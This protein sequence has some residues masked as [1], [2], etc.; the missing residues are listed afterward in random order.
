MYVEAQRAKTQEFRD[1]VNKA[2]DLPR[3]YTEPYTKPDFSLVGHS[4]IFTWGFGRDLLRQ[5]DPIGDA[6][7]LWRGIDSFWDG[8]ANVQNKLNYE[9]YYKKKHSVE[10]AFDPDHAPARPGD[11]TFTSPVVLSWH[12]PS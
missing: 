6:P 5:D 4:E 12:R 2:T 8:I 1:I 3:W 10:D 9:G 11:I 7:G